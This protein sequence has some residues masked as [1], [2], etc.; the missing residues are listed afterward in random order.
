MI[1]DPHPAGG[2][3]ECYHNYRKSNADNEDNVLILRTYIQVLT[4]WPPL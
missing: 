3:A 1:F 2:G 4:V